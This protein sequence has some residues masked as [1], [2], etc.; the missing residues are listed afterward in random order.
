MRGL[1]RD[2]MGRHGSRIGARLVEPCDHPRQLGGDVERDRRFVMS[3]PS[4]SAILRAIPRS[5]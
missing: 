1:A 3:V 2:Q 5:S 4:S